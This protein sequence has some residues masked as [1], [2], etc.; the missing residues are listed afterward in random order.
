MADLLVWERWFLKIH[1]EY[2]TIILSEQFF[3]FIIHCL[4]IYA[5]AWLVVSIA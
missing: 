2:T 4:K 5:H 3:M 1:K